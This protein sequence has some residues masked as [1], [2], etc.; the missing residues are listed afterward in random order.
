VR[1]Q[2]QLSSLVNEFVSYVCSHVG[3]GGHVCGKTLK[4]MYGCGDILKP[5][6]VVDV[7]VVIF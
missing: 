5:C 3:A 4:V 7:V 2:A 6:V 1:A